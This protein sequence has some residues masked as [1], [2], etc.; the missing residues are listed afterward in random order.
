MQYRDFQSRLAAKHE[1]IKRKVIDNQVELAGTPTDCIRI[2]YNKN[3][4]GDILSRVVTKADVISVIWPPMKDV[5]IRKLRKKTSDGLETDTVGSYEIT[6]LVD[7]TEEG[8]NENLFK[9]YFPHGADICAGDLIVRVFLDPDVNHPIILA[10][11]VSNILGTFGQLMLLWETANCVLDVED[12]PEKLATV[13]GN[14]AERRMH[15][16]F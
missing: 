8:V 6:S 1:I 10:V 3:D 9:I 4:E 7:V 12:I 2:R 5:P 13:I 14:M 11:K 16:K 15:L